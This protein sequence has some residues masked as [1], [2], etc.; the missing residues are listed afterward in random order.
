MSR[1]LEQIRSGKRKLVVSLYSPGGMENSYVECDTIEEARELLA[2]PLNKGWQRRLPAWQ[3][4][5]YGDFD[6]YGPEV[7]AVEN[8]VSSVK[9]A[10]TQ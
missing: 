1:I 7:Q 5:A 10:V 4:D 6:P 2:I 3:W 8:E 9:A